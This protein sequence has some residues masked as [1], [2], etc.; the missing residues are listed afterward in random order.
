[1]EPRG[2]PIYRIL[3]KAGYTL[4]SCIDVS[5]C[6]LE[7]PAAA[8]C[9]VVA[10]PIDWPMVPAAFRGGR[11]RVGVEGSRFTLRDPTSLEALGEAVRRGGFV[12]A[13][14]P[15]GV[16]ASWLLLDP[17]GPPGGLLDA[18]RGLVELK[19]RLVVA[20]RLYT[21]PGGWVERAVRRLHAPLLDPLRGRGFRSPV[22]A[23]AAS[24]RA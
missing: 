14:K 22:E 16:A 23:C 18:V 13:E 7:G 8:G 15:L 12:V 5:H 4:H 10:V 1:V 6:I 11:A 17:G 20:V 2:S 9:G 3:A 24:L 21:M 19:P